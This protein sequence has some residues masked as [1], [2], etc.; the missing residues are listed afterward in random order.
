MQLW[1]MLDLALKLALR[2]PA[3]HPFCSWSRIPRLSFQQ[4]QSSQLFISAAP[5]FITMF[6]LPQFALALLFCSPTALADPIHVPLTRRPSGNR[7]VNYYVSAV[8]HL[9]AKYNIPGKFS[10]P[11]G[12]RASSESIQIINLV[13]T[14][15]R[16]HIS[17]RTH[18]LSRDQ[19]RL[20]LHL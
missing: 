4:H 16:C 18:C 14:S 10:S 11:H 9:Q 20:I 5:P 2:P 17:W 13:R 7:D 15:I 6:S 19:I 1:F 8:K 3:R 12:K